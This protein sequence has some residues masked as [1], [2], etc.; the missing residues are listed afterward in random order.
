MLSARLLTRSLR[1][2]TPLKQASQV[3][4]FAATS[5]TMVGKGDI[6]DAVIEDHR[7]LKRYSHNI[8]N[9]GDADTKERWQNHF[10]WEHG[11]PLHRR[12]DCRLSGVREEVAASEGDGREES[13]RS[14]CRKLPGV[15]WIVPENDDVRRQECRSANLP[16]HRSR[17]SS[18]GSR[19]SMATG[20][21][22]SPR[23]ESSGKTSASTLGMRRQRPASAREGD[24]GCGFRERSQKLRTHQDICP[25][26]VN[27]LHC[28]SGA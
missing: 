18:T 2:A 3:R 26:Q 15:Q 16:F 24:L 13:W 21:I 28:A 14:S 1:A 9:E 10:V 22:P 11:P 25:D 4:F 20:P 5:A 19:S 7:E 12:G 8:L 27:S 6:S 17:E 23:S